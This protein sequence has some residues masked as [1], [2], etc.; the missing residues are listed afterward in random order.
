MRTRLTERD[1]SRIVRR[2]INEEEEEEGDDKSELIQ[3]LTDK[4]NDMKNDT[5]FDAT[6]V[7]QIIYNN[8]AHFMNKTDIF[9]SRSGEP[10]SS[11][12]PFAP[13]E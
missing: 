7:A 3:V 4:L 13:K 12:A 5:K 2:V 1:L 9:S 8:C 11:K 6:D 10:L